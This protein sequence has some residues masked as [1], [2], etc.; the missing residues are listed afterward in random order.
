MQDSSL[1]GPLHGHFQTIGLHFQIDSVVSWRSS[2]GLVYD[3]M[4]LMSYMVTCAGCMGVH[5]G[6]RDYYGNIGRGDSEGAGV[7]RGPPR[8]GPPDPH[9]RQDRHLTGALHVCLLRLQH[10]GRYVTIPA[11]YRYM[12]RNM[13]MIPYMPLTAPKNASSTLQNECRQRKVWSV[14]DQWRPWG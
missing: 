14:W 8:G 11:T 2:S 1:T 4:L 12:Q 10:R 13:Y 5:A 3:L 7:P 9:Q 6:N